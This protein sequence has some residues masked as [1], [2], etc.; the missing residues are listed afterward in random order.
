VIDPTRLGRWCGSHTGAR[1]RAAGIVAHPPIA[2]GACL[3]L[4]SV[5]RTPVDMPARATRMHAP[6]A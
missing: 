5:V 1:I 6:L 2:T 4:G 3:R